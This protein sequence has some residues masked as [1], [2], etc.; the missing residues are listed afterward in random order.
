MST[1]FSG[2]EGRFIL[3]FQVEDGTVRAAMRG[4]AKLFPTS[5]LAIEDLRLREKEA[6][7][8]K[9]G[10]KLNRADADARYAIEQFY[11]G[12]FT[13]SHALTVSKSAKAQ[14]QRRFAGARR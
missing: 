6:R 8:A 5:K 1:E 9:Q 12:K 10:W 14:A 7:Y 4:C 11:L 2:A 13:E 3:R